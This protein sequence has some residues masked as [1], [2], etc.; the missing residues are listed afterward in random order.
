VASDASDRIVLHVDAPLPTFDAA[1]RLRQG[2]EHIYLVY[3][4]GR[5][6]FSNEHG[7]QAALMSVSASTQ[8]N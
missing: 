8:V 3:T 2:A 1:G 6:P 7:P 4:E 5:V